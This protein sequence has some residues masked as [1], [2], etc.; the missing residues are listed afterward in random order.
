MWERGKQ[1]IIMNLSVRIINNISKFDLK[2]RNRIK[3]DNSALCSNQLIVHE[4]F[5]ILSQSDQQQ[6]S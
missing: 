3:H 1:K 2:S 5:F 4:I 6:E